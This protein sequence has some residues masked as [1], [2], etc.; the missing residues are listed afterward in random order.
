MTT[1]IDRIPVDVD[2]ISQQ[3]REVKFWR[4]VLTVIA[5]CLFG[6]GW[7]A[8]K[9]FAVAWF[10]VAWCGCAVREGWRAGRH[11]PQGPSPVR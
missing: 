8:F 3:A 11:A 4:S 7:L 5:A 9:F 6:V 2:A 10:A 1:L